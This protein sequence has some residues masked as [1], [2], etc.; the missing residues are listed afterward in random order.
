MTE[1]VSASNLL[2]IH[3]LSINQLINELSTAAQK[4][5]ILRPKLHGSHIRFPLTEDIQ[6]IECTWAWVLMSQSAIYNVIRENIFCL[7]SQN[8]MGQLVDF[9]L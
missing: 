5:I 8:K 2:H 6:P 7:F 4:G 9:H 1:T 3:F